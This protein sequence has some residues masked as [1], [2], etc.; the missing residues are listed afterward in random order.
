MALAAFGVAAAQPDP[1]MT[2]A[3]S[4]EGASNDGASVDEADPA[5]DPP[6]DEPLAARSGPSPGPSVVVRSDPSGAENSTAE[7]DVSPIPPSA[8]A[9]LRDRPTTV[10]ATDFTELNDEWEIYDSPGHGDLG[11]R[12]PSAITLESEPEA[13]GGSLLTITART[14]TEGEEAGQLVSGGMALRRP[15]VYGIYTFRMRVDPDPAEVTSGVAI[16]WPWSNRWPEDG[17]LDMFETWVN[18]ST[19]APVESNFHYLDPLAEPPFDASDDRLFSV[20]HSAVDGTRWH[21]YRFEW[22][23]DRLSM[24]I[25][26]GPMR[27]LTDD[28]LHIPDWLMVPTFQ[29]DAF[30]A[31][32]GTREEAAV[33]A[34]VLLEVDWLVIEE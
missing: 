17:E 25:D 10:F 11:L 29:L 7:E 3:D 15:Q 1:A 31:P 5:L 34:P 13:E 26:D 9:E 4:I 30:P 22:R 21:T 33:E 2:D 14:G 12:R 28:P 27:L 6:S 8:F 18:R 24:A 20:V 16:L 19:R 32:G 23:A